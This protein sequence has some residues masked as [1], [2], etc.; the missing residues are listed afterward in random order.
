MIDKRYADELRHKR[1]TFRRVTGTKKSLL[2]TLV[3]TNGLRN[4]QYARELV[5]KSLTMDALF[6]S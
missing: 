5:D 4:N 2:V 6:G 3:T 1:E